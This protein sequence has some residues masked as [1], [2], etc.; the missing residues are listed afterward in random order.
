MREYF[1]VILLLILLVFSLQFMIWPKEDEFED[2]LRDQRFEGHQ[3]MLVASAGDAFQ[4][5]RDF[6]AQS[7]SSILLNTICM[8]IFIHG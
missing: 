5:G 3:A 7:K 1:I 8:M 2:Q 6:I 4:I